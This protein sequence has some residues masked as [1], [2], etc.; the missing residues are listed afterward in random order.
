MTFIKSYGFR[1]LLFGIFVAIWSWAAWKPIHPDDWLLENY[2]VFFWVPV[3]LFSAR[4]FR[5]SDISY[6]LITL[7]MCLHVVGSHSPYAE[8]PFG[9]TLRIWVDAEL[10]EVA[11][12]EAELL[13]K[14]SIGGFI[15]EVSRLGFL[16]ERRP[17]AGGAWVNTRLDSHAA[18]RK[19]FDR[20]SGRMEVVQED[21]QLLTTVSSAVP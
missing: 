19:L 12:I 8:V 11:R 13:K 21:F 14:L 16:I 2:L 20:F 9:D 3:L 17:L 5:L 15:A 1:L 4:Y 6:G 18:G 7:F 10:H